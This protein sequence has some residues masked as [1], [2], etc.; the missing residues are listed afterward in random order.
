M[1]R[2]KNTKFQ[3]VSVVKVG[4][5]EAFSI[6]DGDSQTNSIVHFCHGVIGPTDQIK[7]P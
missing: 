2:R 5:K 3:R 7:V 4:R 6:Q 1:L